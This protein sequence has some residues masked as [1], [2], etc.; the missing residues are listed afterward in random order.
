MTQA[1]YDDI[2]DKIDLYVLELDIDVLFF[3]LKSKIEAKDESLNHKHTDVH[4]VNG[5][6]LRYLYHT[7]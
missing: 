2:N 7:K 4:S 1:K 6:I 5:Q 3:V